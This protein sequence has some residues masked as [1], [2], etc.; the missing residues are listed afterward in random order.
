MCPATQVLSRHPAAP[1]LLS[2]T[3]FGCP[4]DCGPHWTRTQQDAAIQ[5]GPHPSATKPKAAA[6][7]RTKALER[8]RDGCCRIVKW[9]DIRK[10]PPTNLK[11]SPIAA[12]PHKSRL[13]RMILDLYFTIKT[14]GAP[15]SVNDASN[16]SLAPQHA[17]F[18]LGN[19]IPRIIH[20]LATTPL[21]TQ[22]RFAKIDLKD[23]YWRMSVSPEDAWNFAYVLPGNKP[24]EPTELVIPDALQMGW[25]ESPPYFCAATETARDLAAADLVTNTPQ[26]RHPLEHILLGEPD[27][28]QTPTTTNPTNL[29]P[30]LLEVYVDDFIAVAP[31]T[32]RLH[33]RHISRT[34]LHSIEAIFPGPSIT[35]SNLGP[36]VSLKKLKEEGQWATQKEVLGW[37]I[38]GEK[39][40][41]TLPPSKEEKVLN[42][43]KAARRRERPIPIKD[44]YKLHGKLQSASI[45]I[46]CGKPLL[47]PLDRAIANAVKQDAATIPIQQT[48]QH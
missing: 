20:T 28:A 16:A 30:C 4:V 2:Y 10:N 27:H 25:S 6:V 38:D 11:I 3:A 39:K 29:P 40:T 34:L 24:T 5:R 48:G 43:L 45:A 12:I 46:A 26:P 14:P 23:G 22:F 9:N 19:V 44:F 32:D 1:L 41:I 47:G 42:L 18:E 37:L 31:T 35:K 13:Y 21:T 36:P 8:A 17:M 15:I 7:C 33:L